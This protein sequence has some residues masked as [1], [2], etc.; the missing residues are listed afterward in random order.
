MH[1]IEQ[2][3]HPMKS[4]G[5]EQLLIIKTASRLFK[6]RVS[7]VWDLPQLMIEWHDM[8]E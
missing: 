6:Y 1:V 4:F 5:A 2:G 7:F 8:I 3:A